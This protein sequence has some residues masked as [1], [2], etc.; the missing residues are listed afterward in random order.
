MN[1]AADRREGL[2]EVVVVLEAVGVFNDGLPKEEV[3]EGPLPIVSSVVD[4]VCCFKVTL[5]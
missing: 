4:M 2:L 5:D 3:E 1:D